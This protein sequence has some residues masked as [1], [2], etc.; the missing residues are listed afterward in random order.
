[1]HILRSRRGFQA[2]HSSS[3]YLFYAVEKPVSAEGQRLAHRYSSRAEVDDRYAS[4]QKWGES[5]LDW[6]AYPT[7]LGEHYDVMASESY[8]WWTLM[9]AV[10]R[11][12]ALAALLEPYRDARGGDDLGVEVQ[13]C[14]RKARLLITVFCMF[15]DSGPLFDSGRDSLEALV[16]RLAK[17]RQEILDGNTS[18]LHAVAEYYRAWEDGDEEDDEEDAEEETEARPPAAAPPDYARRSKAELQQECTRRGISFKKSWTRDQLRQALQ[19]PPPAA[20]PARAAGTSRLSQ[21]ARDI[22]ASLT[23][24]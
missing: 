13:D 10:P 14:K 18:F 5:E 22:V 8:D 15:D 3:S 12:P 16:K 19:A 21:A 17:I 1:M 23:A 4:Y 20:A 11:T 6:N 2:D 24:P 7:L 9:I